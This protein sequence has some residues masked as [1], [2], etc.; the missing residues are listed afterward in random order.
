MSLAKIRFHF[1][2]NYFL[3]FTQQK[4]NLNHYLKVFL[5]RYYRQNKLGNHALCCHRPNHINNH[6][7]R[8]PSISTHTHTSPNAMLTIEKKTKFI[9]N[10]YF[11]KLIWVFV[12]FLIRFYSQTIRSI[13]NGNLLFA[14]YFNC[15]TFIIKTT[16]TQWY[17]IEKEKE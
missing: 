8:Y 2:A 12:C 9:L 10:D 6:S 13:P 17:Q 15:W 11:V 14:F 16:W 3:F 5:T 7:I 4:K 1:W